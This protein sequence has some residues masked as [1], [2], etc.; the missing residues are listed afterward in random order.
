MTEVKIPEDQWDDD[1]AAVITSWSYEDGAEVKAGDT[2][3]EI[4]VE[5]AQI[6]IGAPASG[7]LH[8]R[9]PED[10]VV[11]RGAVIATIE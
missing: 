11:K 7:V 3:A 6:E 5:K 8:I 9:E 2:I 4:M 10:A 1:K